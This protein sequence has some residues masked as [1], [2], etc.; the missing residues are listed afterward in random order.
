VFR[1]SNEQRAFL[2][3]LDPT[4]QARAEAETEAQRDQFEF[5]AINVASALDTYDVTGEQFAAILLGLMGSWSKLAVTR[6]DGLTQLELI[7]TIGQCTRVAALAYRHHRD[8]TPD[9]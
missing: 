6:P 7:Q 8:V 1:L 5:F 9:A 4:E 2:V 3:A